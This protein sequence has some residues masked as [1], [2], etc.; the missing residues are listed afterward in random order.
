MAEEQTILTLEHNLKKNPG[1]VISM[2]KLADVL[3]A[4]NKDLA[5]AEKL[6]LITQNMPQ[7]KAKSS[8]LLG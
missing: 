6:L 5:K 1:D 8:L 7:L 2:L 3:L 4:T